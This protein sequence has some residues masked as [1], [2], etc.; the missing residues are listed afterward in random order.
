MLNQFLWTPYI[1]ETDGVTRYT[2]YKL[3]Y[4]II[5][6]SL[7]VYGIS[8]FKMILLH[9][10]CWNN[11]CRKSAQI[12]HCALGTS[13]FLFRM[14]FF[15]LT[16]DPNMIMGQTLWLGYYYIERCFTD[17]LNNVLWAHLEFQ[18]QTR[19][20]SKIKIKFLSVVY[21]LLE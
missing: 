1:T 12:N 10:I 21:N 4:V 17:A 13:Y 19:F 15:S 7:I 8:S 2:N 5:I 16:S 11:I 14:F 3:I 20:P 18:M 6:F 9:N